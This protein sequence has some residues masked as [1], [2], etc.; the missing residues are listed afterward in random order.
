MWLLLLLLQGKQSVVDIDWKH[1]Y[2]GRGHLLSADQVSQYGRQI[3]EVNR[4]AVSLA[5]VACPHYTV[6]N[7]V[8]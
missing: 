1:K 5:M 6:C 8:T 2:K 3:L 7:L 4:R